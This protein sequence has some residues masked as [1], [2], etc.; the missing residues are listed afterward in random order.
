MRFAFTIDDWFGE[1]CLFSFRVCAWLL[2]WY[3]FDFCLWFDCI[4]DACGLGYLLICSFVCDLVVFRLGRWFVCVDC[5][6]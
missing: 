4:T 1:V 2:A 3:I 6:S 5:C